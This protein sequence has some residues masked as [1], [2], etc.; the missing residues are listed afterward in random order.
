MTS[1]TIHLRGIWRR[2]F[3]RVPIRTAQ[4]IVDAVQE[5]TGRRDPLLPPRALNFV[6]GSDDFETAGH[7][8]LKH[9]VEIGGL[10]PDDRVLDIGSG[11]GRMAVPLT[12]YISSRGEYQGLEI[13]RVGVDW[14]R[15]NITPRFPHFRFQWADVYN[16]SYNPAGKSQPADY[17][18]P[19]EDGRFSFVFLTSVF[20]HMLPA[21]TAHYLSEIARVLRPGGRCF[22]TFFLLNAESKAQIRM[23]KST[24]PFPHA[25]EGYMTFKKRAPELAIAFEEE[26]VRDRHQSAG[27]R[28]LE[29]IRYGSWCARGSYTSYQDIVL[30]EKARG[31]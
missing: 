19:F 21:E 16:K 23:G 11:V 3:K 8:F 7:E 6:G 15:S 26:W 25:G 4:S 17:R 2:P 1:L 20:T 18:F 30:S 12:R 10:K 24:P 14:C 9:F 29:P 31:A 13:V 5:A 22:A 27:L 28:V